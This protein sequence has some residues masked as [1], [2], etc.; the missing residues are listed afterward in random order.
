MSV[1]AGMSQKWGEVCKHHSLFATTKWKTKIETNNKAANGLIALDLFPN[2]FLLSNCYRDWYPLIEV[3]IL[4]IWDSS[5]HRSQIYPQIIKH[6][7]FTPSTHAVFTLHT[8][9]LACNCYICLLENAV[10]VMSLDVGVSANR[11]T[12]FVSDAL[13]CCNA[14]GHKWQFSLTHRWAQNHYHILNA[15]SLLLSTHAFPLF[16]IR[17]HF[18]LSWNPPKSYFC[19]FH[20]FITMA[21]SLNFDV[22]RKCS[23]FT[24]YVSIIEVLFKLLR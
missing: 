22:A 19:E 1:H 16:C 13:K 24:I 11:M 21:F 20:T 7:R 17:F 4:H 3:G 14:H 8:W 5:K 23:F 9:V 15:R 18:I 2:F 10:A 6:C 12:L